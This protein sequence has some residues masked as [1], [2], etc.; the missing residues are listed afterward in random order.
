MR[1]DNFYSR[2]ETYGK[3]L[4]IRVIPHRLRHTCATLLLN[5]GAPILTVQAILGHKFVD[6][7]LGYARLYDGTV[8]ADYYQAMWQIERCLALPEDEARPMV[9]HGELLVM[10]DLLKRGT[11][12]DVQAETLQTLRAGLVALAGHDDSMKLLKDGNV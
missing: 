1:V 9:S 10:V 7:T 5:A 2:F 11:L 3:P 12:N 8:A 4:G 6:T